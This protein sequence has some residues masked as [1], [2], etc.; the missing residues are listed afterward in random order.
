LL[1]ADFYT[2]PLTSNNDGWK[3]LGPKRGPRRSRKSWRRDSAAA[4]DQ[5]NAITPQP[6][7]ER[8]KEEPVVGG[9]TMKQTNPV[10]KAA[11]P[12]PVQTKPTSPK[13]TLPASPKTARFPK[14]LKQS[15][16]AAA[17]ARRDVVTPRAVVVSKATAKKPE[18]PKKSTKPPIKSV[19]PKAV[20]A[21]PKPAAV[22]T[23]KL[24]DAPPKL[25]APPPVVEV[26]KVSENRPSSTRSNN[27]ISIRWTP[28]KGQVKSPSAVTY[29]PMATTLTPS[30]N[31]E[32]KPFSF[33]ASADTPKSSKVLNPAAVE[34]RPPPP[35]MR[36]HQPQ[37]Q[38]PL[39]PMRYLH[40]PHSLG[41]GPMM[42]REEDSPV[43][44][45][46]LPY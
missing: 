5:N 38:N 22:S 27:S 16:K 34:F 4:I 26:S 31:P 11:V 37:H 42:Q 23:K 25:Q 45:L 17:D 32:A 29:N 36:P 2:M 39:M 18:E 33:P 15:P 44:N 13:K 12:Q 41:P 19:S 30:L 14:S 6:T 20:Q 43:S 46:I 28:R 7:A 3:T 40:M 9:G 8:P 24:Y 10:K 35:A 1:V 21:T